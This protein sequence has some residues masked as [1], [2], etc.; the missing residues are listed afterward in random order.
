MTITKKHFIN[1]AKIIDDNSK[2]NDDAK[3]ILVNALSNYFKSE[4]KNFDNIRFYNACFKTLK[5]ISDDQKKAI[6]VLQSKI[7]TYEADIDQANRKKLR[8]AND[9]KGST[10]LF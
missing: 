9:L 2:H 5:P 7:N 6:K 3:Q 8:S 10:K 4:N 1:I